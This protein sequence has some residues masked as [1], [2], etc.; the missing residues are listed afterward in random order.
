[1]PPTGRHGRPQIRIS[2]LQMIHIRKF[3]KIRFSFHIML[4]LFQHLTFWTH[5]VRSRIKSGMTG[6]VLKKLFWTRV[7]RPYFNSPQKGYD[8]YSRADEEKGKTCVRGYLKPGNLPATTIPVRYPLTPVTPQK[9]RNIKRTAVPA[10]ISLN[11]FREEK[12]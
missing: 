9:I 1:M 6:L 2:K 12:I 5:F 3:S 8:L 10:P 7:D 11:D 4:N